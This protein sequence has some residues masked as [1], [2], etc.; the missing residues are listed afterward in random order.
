MEDVFIKVTRRAHP[1]RFTASYCSVRRSKAALSR[2]VEGLEAALGLPL[3]E[4]RR[5]GLKQTE[6]GRT[7]VERAGALLTGS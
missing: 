2:R 6:D 5:R 1:T 3:V 4:R 7:L